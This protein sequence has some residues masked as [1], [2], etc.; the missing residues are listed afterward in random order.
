VNRTMRAAN[1]VG[2]QQEVEGQ[3]PAKREARRFALIA[4]A[5]L[6]TEGVVTSSLF[7]FRHRVPFLQEVPAIPLAVFL[8]S[9][10]LPFAIVYW[11]EGRDTRA[12]GL[13][14]ERGKSGL[15]LLYAVAGLALPALFV[16]LDRRLA[17]EFV[18][19]IVY[20]GVAEEIFSR[21]YLMRRLCDWL[22]DGKG[23]LLNA[24][25]FGLAH[26]ISRL[27]QHGLR[28]PDRLAI[29]FLQT[30]AGGLLLGYI[31]LRAKSIV[32]GAILHTSMNA[33]L[34]RLIEMVGG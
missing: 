10:A 5:A 6:A 31:Y 25:I 33:Y 26:V 30:C 7:V 17:A 34:S 4:L 21:G 13:C 15:Y 16:G 32:P 27:S 22:G 9:W 8:A 24:L 18:D 28:Y 19:Q 1:V 14:I 2:R 3:G 23:L 20:I 29:I 11:V 12:L